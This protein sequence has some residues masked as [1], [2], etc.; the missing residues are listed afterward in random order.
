M[1]ARTAIPLGSID[2]RE[3]GI[4]WIDAGA[5]ARIGVCN[6]TIWIVDALPRLRPLAVYRR[7]P[8]A[9]GDDDILDA[10]L[11]AGLPA[12]RWS[13]VEVQSV[14]LVLDGSAIVAGALL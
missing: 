8:V 5:G 2:L 9:A 6:R 1:V 3:L 13:W 11:G 10:L 7:I 4:D 12:A 14:G